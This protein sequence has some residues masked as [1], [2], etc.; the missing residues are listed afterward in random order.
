[1][2]ALV[3]ARLAVSVLFVVNGLSLAAWFPRLAQVQDDI[4]L[5]DAQLGIVL[6]CGAAGGL[7]VGPLG[8][9][10][11][12]RWNSARVSV[13]SF[14]LIAPVL[15][16]VGLA[17]NGWVLACALF[18]IGALDAVMDGAMNAHGLRVQSFYGRSIINGFHA[19]WS[20]GMVTG[21][22]VGTVSLAAGVPV[23]W[24]L[25]GVALGSLIPLAVTARWLLPGPDPDSHLSDSEAA[26]EATSGVDPGSVPAPAGRGAVLT[27][28]TLL[29]GL[30][31]LLAVVVEDIPAR[32]SS[33]YLAGIGAPEAVV[34][35]GFTAFTIAMMVGRFGGDR[36]VNRFGE[37][38][39]V[40]VSMATAAVT[41]AAALLIG[42]PWAYIAACI[43][44]GLAVATL[45][46]AAMHA[47]TQIPGVRP[48]MGVA[49]VGWLARAGFIVAPLA[50]GA[51]AERFGIAW[52]LT[53]PIIAALLLV[54]LSAILRQPA[55]QPIP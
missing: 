50:V 48:A 4:G 30:F 19:Y 13:V 36:L 23:P 22:V 20:L 14:L 46:P 16:I 54:P 34:G 53:V 25:V 8:G 24:M 41:L 27:K 45:F 49:T 9:V 31:T 10:L 37:A 11:V 1:M 7:V 3:R 17:P 42:T 38:A 28:V 47:A 40:R 51:V 2:T 55:R 15:P 32:W 52:G 44:I 21:A 29:L 39:V 12:A 33:I 6:A 26:L 43:V 18:W 35:I 5:N